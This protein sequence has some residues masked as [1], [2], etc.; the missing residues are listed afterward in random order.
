VRLLR[1]H[2][3]AQ[4]SFQGDVQAAIQELQGTHQCLLD[5][6][7][8][9]AAAQDENATLTARCRE[10]VRANLDHMLAWRSLKAQADALQGEVAMLSAANSEISLRAAAVSAR[11]TQLTVQLEGLGARLVGAEQQIQQREAALCTARAALLEK[12]SGLRRLE[13]Q[14]AVLEQQVVAGQQGTS[15]LDSSIR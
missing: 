9:L 5:T 1:C 2:L 4:A 7:D 10:F 13:C 8:S 3:H 11:N 6:Q 12:D 14:V 15:Q